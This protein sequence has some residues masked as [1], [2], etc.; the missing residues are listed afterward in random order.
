[1][2]DDPM[3]DFLAREKA[4]LGEDADFFANPTP[5]AASGIDAFPDLTSP[6][7][8]PESTPAKPPTPQPQGI[9]A[10]PDID[11]PAVDGTQIRVTGAAGTGEDEDVMKFESAF[12]DL[13]GETGSQ[14]A[15]KPVFNA[16]SP[17]PYGASPYPPAATAA[18]AAPRS[19]H[20]S[21]LPAPTFNNILPTADEDTEPIK[22]WRARQAE[23]IQ[24][25]DE[26]DKK[27]RDEMSDKAE[28][29]IDQFYEDYNKMKEKNIRENKES[30]AEFLEKLQEGVAKG[31]AWERIS[32]LI[33]LE[34][35]QSK[36][37]RP[38]VPG[39]SDLARMKEIL[40][41]LRREGDKAPGAAGF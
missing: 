38:S 10:F 12:P 23:E 17:Q 29:A 14:P 35:S 25:R 2:S 27:R 9:D 11:T 3:A 40:L 6:A 19:P 28:K 15:P 5:S 37:I 1:M 18:A 20:P 36:T 13:S 26:S 39:G 32:D 34:N 16:L 4:A 24:K 31:T 33:S 8:E 41:A 22:A 7:V 30:E 21:I